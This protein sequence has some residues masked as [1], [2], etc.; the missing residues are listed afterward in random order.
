MLFQRDVLIRAIC[1]Y[2]CQP[3]VRVSWHKQ[4]VSKKIRFLKCLGPN[5][6]CSTGLK[7]STNNTRCLCSKYIFRLA[8]YSDY[9]CGYKELT[10]LWIYYQKVGNTV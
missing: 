5:N 4:T 2:K 7:H 6:L 3:R 8:T 9:L 10:V 1:E